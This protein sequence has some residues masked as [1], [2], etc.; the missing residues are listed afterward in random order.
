MLSLHV[1]AGAS[2]EFDSLFGHLAIENSSHG[3]K[4]DYALNIQDE[5]N[6]HVRSDV[7]A[8]FPRCKTIID[9]DGLAVENA[10][11]RGRI[12]LVGTRWVGFFKVPA[13]NIPALS[14]LTET[15][16]AWSTF[17]SGGVFL[18]SSGVVRN[19][20]LFLFS[21]PSGSGKTTIARQ[22]NDGGTPFCI[23]A[24]CLFPD[25]EGNVIAYPT[26][27]SDF[28]GEVPMSDPFQVTCVSFIAQSRHPTIAPLSS[29]VAAMQLL[30]N[31][32]FLLDAD[33]FK[34]QALDTACAIASR[35]RC[36]RLQFS[37]D[38]GFWGILEQA[39]EG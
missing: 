5:E 31:S 7:Q 8:K 11:F 6:W 13:G 38:T 9:S 36:Y 25:E 33:E 10:A 26:P 34:A 20:E 1:A 29:S 4:I 22:L 30:Q 12:E 35:L 14:I 37:R 27:F 32:R 18:H 21:G 24:C 2:E 39:L 23:E 3:N 19:N 17:A 16:V 28:K 15:F